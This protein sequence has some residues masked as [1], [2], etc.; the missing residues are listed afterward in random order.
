MSALVRDAETSRRAQPA[1]T[2]TI[3]AWNDWVTG[4]GEVE[5]SSCGGWGHGG[6]A[7]SAELTGANHAHE[8][9]EIINLLPVVA[10]SR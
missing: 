3:L 5:D 4:G 8:K 2:L 9:S 10:A 1:A 6:V 7:V